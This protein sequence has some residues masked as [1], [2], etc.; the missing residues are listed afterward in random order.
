MSRMTSSLGSLLWHSL[1]CGLCLCC[2]PCSAQTKPTAQSAI[3]VR[4]DPQSGSYSIRESGIDIDVLTSDVAARIDGR[5]LRG[6]EYPTRKIDTSTA[7]SDI[8]DAQRWTVT[9]SGVAGAPDLIYTID[10]ATGAPFAEI[11]LQVR[12]GTNHDIHVEAMRSIEATSNSMPALGASDGQD[13]VLS[14]SFSEDHPQLG[15]YDLGDAKAGVHQAVGSQLIYNLQ[16]HRSLFVGALTSDRLLTFID[17]GV[18]GTGP[19]ARIASFHAEATGITEFQKSYPLQHATAAD[20][21]VLK[22]PV[23]PG[24]SLASEKL[25]I[26]VGP[27]YHAL[28]DQY[29]AWIRV[30]HHA[31]V[32]APSS[33]GWWSWTA[34]YFG[35]NEGTAWSN[36]QWLAQHLKPLGY[37]FFHIDEGYQYARGEYT[38]PDAS[39]FPNGVAA[40]EQKVIGAGLTPGIWTAPFEVSERS[41]VYQHH[42]EWLVKNAGGAPIHLGFVT[43]ES[44][45]LYALDPTHPG[46]QEYL[47]KTYR[48]LAQQWGIRYIKL[49]FMDEAAIEGFYFR[50]NTTAMQAQRIGLGV[51][52]DAVGDD[53][54]L[55]KDGSAMLNPVGIVD[56]G[57]ISQD[58]GHTFGATKDAATGVAARYYMNRNFF[59]SDPDAFSVSKQVLPEQTWHGGVTPLTLDEAKASIALSAVAGGMYEI[60]DDLPRLTAEPDRLALIENRD[61]IDMAL[62]GRASLP[63]DLMT[64]QPE[65][66][67][68]SIFF[69]KETKR[70]SILTIFNWTGKP[71]SHTIS[72]ASL[73]LSREP[74][75]IHD[76]FDRSR[77]NGERT[78]II[79]VNQ[80]PYSVRMLKI[81]RD[82]PKAAPRVSIQPVTRG[83]NGETIRFQARP[84]DS[85][86][87]ITSYRWDFG[88]GVTSDGPNVEHAFTTEG[89]YT[90]KLTAEG[91]EG[92]A[93]HDSFRIDVSGKIPTLFTPARNL[94]QHIPGDAT[95]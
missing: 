26:G 10:A 3:D 59:V 18:A 92:V 8:G 73:G 38:T 25:V 30:L 42:P 20:Q 16:S 45:S 22:L 36:A 72:L 17:L 9:F 15:I 70:Q 23:R 58:T 56:T 34:Y 80:P 86:Q 79:T 28:L 95:P 27:D 78:G 39:L 43:N 54:L 53:V 69:L 77:F 37:N 87:A 33:M 1:L 24:E 2:L 83:R 90:V 19:N 94:R 32:T 48:T 82:L 65:D 11:A 66:E 93:G 44:D 47:R 60:G 63:V 74:Y 31:R 91:V 21:V 7:N 6:S 52:R 5:W 55:D 76:V 71:H 51:I 67:Q 84:A 64:Y 40:L 88:D 49:D 57:R 62:L 50:P 81:E 61:L 35:L 4:I 13:R 89:H 85:E 14:D 75:S 68:P 12:N 46:A 29:G 41:W